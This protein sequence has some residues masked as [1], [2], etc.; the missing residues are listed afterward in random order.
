MKKS[1]VVSLIL[2]VVIFISAFSFNNMGNVNAASKKVLTFYDQGYHQLYVDKD[3]RYIF[4]TRGGSYITRFDTKTNKET[5]YKIGKS[6]YTYTEQLKVVGKYVYFIEYATSNNKTKIYISRIDKN[7]KNK[8]RLRKI[9]DED[10]YA[11]MSINNKRIYYC[12]LTAN[13]A[14]LDKAPKY[15]MNLEG[16]DVKEEKNIVFKSDKVCNPVNS[17]YAKLTGDGT[18]V[19]KT[20]SQGRRIKA[21]VSFVVNNKKTGKKKTYAF[22]CFGGRYALVGDYIVYSLETASVKYPFPADLKQKYYVMRYDGKNKKELK[23]VLW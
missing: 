16:K 6:A 12:A 1:K 19:S 7:G 20:D 11:V 10:G 23:K 13:M 2:A 21:K 22:N 17:N 15:S 9:Y 5:A 4:I 18:F 3:D 8:K 14:Y